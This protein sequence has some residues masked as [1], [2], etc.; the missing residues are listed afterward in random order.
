M[1]ETLTNHVVL[2]LQ[3]LI[4]EISPVRV[5]SHD[6]THECR[7]EDHVLGLLFIKKLLYGPTIQQVQ[8]TMRSPHQT[9][10]SFRNEVL[11]DGRPYQPPMS[12]DIYFTLF[13]H[14]LCF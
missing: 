11:P 13:I 3:I 6:T 8:F 2:Y 14:S 4:N 1:P 12:R 7:R 10:I 5:I 9:G